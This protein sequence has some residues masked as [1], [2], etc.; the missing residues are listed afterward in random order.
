MERFHRFPGVGK[1]IARTSNSHYPNVRLCLHHMV[2]IGQ[3]LIRRKKAAGNARAALINA[4][5]FPVAEVTLH[6]AAWCNR[7]MNPPGLMPRLY[8]KTWMIV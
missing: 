1:W 4:I 6:I 5:V 3:C 2:K 8:I 7:Q